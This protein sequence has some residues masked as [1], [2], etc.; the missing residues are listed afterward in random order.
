MTLYEQLLELIL[1]RPGITKDSLCESFDLSLYRLNRALRIIDRELTDRAVIHSDR[2]VWI[3]AVD[4]NKC[5]GILWD[6][7]NGTMGQCSRTPEFSD[8]RCYDHSESENSEMVAILQRIRTLIGPADPNSYLIG[9]LPVET[10]EE[11]LQRLVSLRPIH[12]N[13]SLQR[14]R[15]IK[16]VRG[17]LA[18]LRW[19][20]TMRRQRRAQEIP[21]EFWERH[22]RS[23]IN[24]FAFVVKKYFLTLELTPDA[25]K[26]EV[27][28]AWRRLARKYHP[29]LEDG[30]EE[31]M[32][33]INLAKER[34]FRLKRWD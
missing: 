17:A 12:K 34:I 7:L 24:S 19:K 28:K 16:I 26:E 20:E 31:R 22:K 18:F 1:D 15:T 32:K 5:L 14:E 9:Q 11:L 4:H 21:L 30:D 10:V 6:D 13:D 8:G 29:D 25:A 23:S 33:L 2:G 27:L 3:I